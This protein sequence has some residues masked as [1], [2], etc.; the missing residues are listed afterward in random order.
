MI[1]R[2]T[3]S[4]SCQ[5]PT[6]HGRLSKLA[7][8]IVRQLSPGEMLIFMQMTE[9]DRC[10]AAFCKIISNLKPNQ[11]NL[12]IS[13]TILFLHH[14]LPR[15]KLYLPQR[16]FQVQWW[17]IVLFIYCFLSVLWGDPGCDPNVIN[18]SLAAL[19]LDLSQ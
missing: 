12:L 9:W 1:S 17:N 7:F 14:C 6:R 4:R 11:Y 16:L 8:L 2:K 15:E 13:Y 19:G 18:G 5:R 10:E 3:Y